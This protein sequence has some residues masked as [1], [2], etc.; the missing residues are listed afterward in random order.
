M[1]NN[2]NFIHSSFAF[3]IESFSFH[4]LTLSCGR[5]RISTIP[6]TKRGF[7]CRGLSHLVYH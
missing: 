7:V 2:I 5:L 6:I 3:S 4:P 1:T